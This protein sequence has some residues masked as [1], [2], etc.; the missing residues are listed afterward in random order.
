L[1]YELNFF[2][3]KKYLFII[4]SIIL[5]NKND[6]L[7]FNRYTQSGI[8]TSV[9]GQL[10]TIDTISNANLSSDLQTKISSVDTINTT[11]GTLQTNVG[12]LQTNVGTLQTNVGTLQTN[13]GTLQTNVGTLQTNLGTLQ[14]TVDNLPT[15][16]GGDGSGISLDDTVSSISDMSSTSMPNFAKEWRQCTN[17]GTPNIIDIC[18]SGD[19]KV[20]L[21]CGWGGSAQ[22]S[23]NYGETWSSP[24]DLSTYIWSCS[25]NLDGKYI[26]VADSNNFKISS[27][28]GATFVFPYPRPFQLQRSAL[29]ATGKYIVCGCGQYQ[30]LQV[31]TDYGVS[32]TQKETTAW[33]WNDVATA[34]DGSV[35]YGC[36][37]GGLIKKSVNYGTTWTTIYTDGTSRSFK[38][39]SCSSDGK[40]ILAAF[41]SS[42]QLLLSTDYGANFN[43][44]GTSAS[45]YKVSMSKNGIYMVA[46]VNGSA[47]YYSINSGSSWSSVSNNQFCAISMSYNGEMIYNVSPYNKPIINRVSHNPFNTGAPTIASSGSTYFDTATNKLYIYNGSAWKSVTLA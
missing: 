41:A 5:K 39:M 26:V 1:R 19:G 23:T 18:C 40:Y 9:N 8:F 16:S 12:T 20:A 42:S 7:A 13:V 15:Q 31:S 24:S 34:M 4:M 11:V 27:D 14:T 33:Y 44:V 46:S 45:Y 29:S 6:K 28:Y 25:M 32:W 22:F 30:G 17:A 36:S 35:M 37:D 38:S 2:I 43:L 21:V 10:S 3:N 47:V